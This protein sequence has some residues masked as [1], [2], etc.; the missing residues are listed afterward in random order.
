[1]GNGAV[2]QLVPLRFQKEIGVITGIVG[3]AGGVGGFFLPTVLGFFK[4]ATGSYGV[5]FAIFAFA[6][7]AA[8]AILRAVQEGW[9]FHDIL[10]QIPS[11]LKRKMALEQAKD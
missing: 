7:L 4:D 3:A 2:F 9:T 6:S 1:M 5:G 10:L 8:L 11:G